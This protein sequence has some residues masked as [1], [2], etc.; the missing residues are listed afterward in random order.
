MK[1]SP[2]VRSKRP[3]WF[4]G[5]VFILSL[6][7]VSCSVLTSLSQSSRGSSDP[8]KQSG[9]Q[10]QVL[11]SEDEE[12]GASGES[13]EGESG[14]RDDGDGEDEDS[15]IADLTLP[16]C[17]EKPTE[18]ILDI[19]HTW[20]FSPNRDLEQ[21]R[22]DGQT[23]ASAF[24]PLTVSGS[25]VIMEDCRIPYTTSGFV[26]TDEGPCDI[27]ASGVAI[28]SADEPY[29]KKGEIVITF[30]ESVDT[31]AMSVGALNCPGYSGP[32]FTYFPYSLTTRAFHIQ[33][34]GDTQYEDADPDIS[35]QFRYH[36]EWTL[37][38]EI[39]FSDDE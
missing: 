15:E 12:E 9:S 6:M 3:I 34:G 4:V 37:H 11:A 1:T 8:D 32:F 16:V 20:D 19:A 14:D 26:Q 7:V 10:E 25:T 35:L 23:A 24:C 22:V 29:C 30:I 13:G 39:F 33:S 38:S 27:H 36:K 17:P 31:D 18:F 2:I 5:F 28:I 21:M